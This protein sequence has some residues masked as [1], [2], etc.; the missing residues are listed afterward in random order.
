MTNLAQIINEGESALI[1]KIRKYADKTGYSRFTP[2]DPTV[3]K[4]S[5][6]GFSSGLIS[7]LKASSEIP[8]LSFGLEFMQDSITAFGVEQAKKHRQRGVSLEMFLGLMKYF[9]QSYH[10]L[11]DGSTLVPKSLRWAHNYVERYFDRIELGFVSEWERSAKELNSR[12]EKLLLERNAE[13]AGMNAKLEQEVIERKRIEQQIKKLNID[14]ER[15][16]TARTL[17]LQR[18]NDQNNYKLKELLLL[19]RFSS[20]NLSKIRLNKL[21]HII[22]SALTSNAPLFFD[23]AMLFMMNEKTQVL[24]G[25]LG[26]TRKDSSGN[27]AS[28]NWDLSD[29]YIASAAESELSRELRSCRIELERDKGIFYRVV[30]EKKALLLNSRHGMKKDLPDFFRRLN[31]GS[32]LVMPLMGKNG[33]FGV[34]VVDNPLSLREPGKNDLKFLQLF[35]NHA[36]IAIENLML[37]STL[38][39]T[40]SQLH[41]AQE[42]LI[43]RERLAT[44]GEMA[45]GIAHELKG[46]MVAIGGFARRLAG[47]IPPLSQEAGYVATIIEEEKRLENML[48]DVLSFSK[49]TTICYESCSISDIVEGA[50]SMLDHA[51]SRNKV[52]LQKYFPKKTSLLYG[53]CQ[54]LKQVFINLVQNSVDAMRDGGVL[55]VTITSS[56]LDR[57]KAVAVRI[58]DSGGGIPQSLR[59]SIF[60]PFVTTKKSGTGL[61]L[62]IANRIVS[63]HL[64]KIRVKNNTEGGAEFTVLLPCHE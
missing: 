24:Q 12:H 13:L 45:A 31:L 30:T 50:L 1:S 57:G 16:V 10:D 34:V 44:I 21:T 60:N 58:S 18:I 35:S 42:Q 37:Y 3:W 40:I 7:A 43:H 53:D 61:G 52:T 25:M 23:R 36:G 9:R 54:Q 62:P 51:F 39:D 20:L 8:E 26:I 4:I 55:K 38:E 48:T 46:P 5:I 41:E 28:D 2:S 29:E 19:N 27:E 64:G 56:R 22:L 32:M 33:I 59:N 49:K 63:N 14:L 6:N 11:L 17:Q 15:R 47:K